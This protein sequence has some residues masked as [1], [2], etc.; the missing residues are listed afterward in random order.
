MRT[1][2]TNSPEAAARIIA[3]AM[4]SDGHLCKSELDMLERVGAHSQLGLT[5]KQLHDVLHTLCEDLLATSHGDWESA[6]RVSA[7]TFSAVM[8]EI[9]DAD[10][11]AKVLRLCAIVIA[12][13]EQVTEN[14]S[15][16]LAAA[17]E[18]WREPY[19]MLKSGDI[20]RKMQH[21]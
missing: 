6:C 9:T 11:R 17:V 1:Y 4:L 20:T 15:R 19:H 7:E 10:L 16:I 18:Q 13:D 8:A 21:A 5:P 2:P 3:L 12:A 14:E